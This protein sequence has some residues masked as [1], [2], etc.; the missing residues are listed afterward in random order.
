[1]RVTTVAYAFGP[2]VAVSAA[3]LFLSH[4]PVLPAPTGNDKVAHVIAYTA[5]GATYL[6]ALLLGT[7]WPRTLVLGFV[8]AS[9]FGVTDEAHQSFVPGRHADV[10]D[11]LADVVGAALGTALAALVYRRRLR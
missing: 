3:I 10:G 2:A 9:L 7:S 8:L 11:V 4:Q 1:M 6:H 5:V